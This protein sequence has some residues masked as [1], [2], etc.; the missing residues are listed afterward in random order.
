MKLSVFNQQGKKSDAQIEVADSVFGVELN[1]PLLAQYVYVYLS[2]QRGSI[3]NTK[4]RSEVSGG[5]KKPHAQKGTGKARAGSNR[6]PI[7][8]H[9]GVTFGPTSDRN[10]KKNM[11]VKMKIAAFKSAISAL[12][13]SN[14]LVIVDK[15]EVAEKQPT[16]Q[17]T[18]LK[19][20]F[21]SKKITL[22]TKEVDNSVIKATRNLAGIKVKHVGEL[23]TY[24]LMFGGK[25]IM[26]SDAAALINEKYN[27]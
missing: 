23:N 10:W 6:S 8:R 9:G 27:K 17:M 1:R 13:N 11:S 21:G 4:D 22:V 18:D 2:N 7:W 16:K 26:L 5:G 19:K 14:E 24:D 3:S 12:V 25:V 15:I 20:S